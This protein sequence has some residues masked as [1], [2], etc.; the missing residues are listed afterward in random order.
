MA[1]RVAGCI[2]EGIQAVRDHYRTGGKAAP[3]AALHRVTLPDNTASVGIPDGWKVDPGCAGGT[4]SITGPHGDVVD[5]NLS[6]TALDPT[7]R[8]VQQMQRSGTQ[9]AAIAKAVVYPS[10][11][12]L[13][14]AFPI[15][16]DLIFR[17]GG[18]QGSAN[19]QIA[20]AEQIPAP[21][22][23]RCVHVTGQSHRDGKGIYEINSVLCSSTPGP[24]GMY[25]FNLFHS[26]IAI[27]FA[28]QERATATAIVASFQVN[29]ALINQRVAAATAPVIAAMNKQVEAQAAQAIGNIHQIGQQTTARINASE[30]A[31]NTQNAAWN[32]G[33]N[34]NAQKAQGFSNYLL[35]QTVVQNNNTGGHSTDWNSTADALVKTNPNRFQYVD[36]PNY[37][38]GTDN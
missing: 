11:V 36:T 8:M 27:A 21:K 3:T 24:T 38:K 37:I 34:T 12:D 6:P 18:V 22:G 33:Q 26:A 1:H 2:A 15:I 23:Q 19:L 5:L 13:A 29:K 14:K 4:M 16:F 32:A 17:I 20:K 30:A 31:N 9:K 7:N 10:N 28:D 25:G 35:D